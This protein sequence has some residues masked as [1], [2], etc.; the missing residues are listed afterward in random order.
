MAP[1][2]PQAT[3][4]QLMRAEIPADISFRPA[5]ALFGA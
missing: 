4:E 5:R 3:F 2:Y 1:R